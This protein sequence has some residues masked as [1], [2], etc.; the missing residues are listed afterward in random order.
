[1]AET[2]HT[3]LDRLA[4]MDLADLAYWCLE[5]RRYLEAKAEA[6]KAQMQE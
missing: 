1:M 2:V 3:G 5:T 6:M 4:E